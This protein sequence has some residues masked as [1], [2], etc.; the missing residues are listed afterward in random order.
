MKKVLVILVILSLLFMGAKCGGK[1][2]EVGPKPFFGGIEG[3][4][5]SFG[6][7]APLSEFQRAT[8]IPVRVVLKNKGEYSIPAGKIKVKLSGVNLANYN[9]Q[10]AANYKA[11][12]RELKGV[13]QLN[14]EGDELE[15]NFGN[16]NYK[17]QIS[18]NFI[19]ETL[20]AKICYEY[21]TSTEIPICIQPELATETVCSIAEEKVKEGTVSGSP[22]Q[23]TS[24]TEETVGG[25]VVKFN[26]VIENKG[27]GTVYSPTVTCE[28]LENTYKETLERG[29]F[30]VD[31]ETQGVL[32]TPENT[33]S[34][35]LKLGSDGKATVVCHVRS[36]GAYTDFLRM[37]LTFKY[38]SET[39]KQI[40]VVKGI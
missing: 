37:K 32:C 16:L 1:K 9:L 26:I 19:Q 38:I 29:K 33:N 14:P 35:D 11:S 23:V 28:D 36:K 34:F 2:K 5:A 24:V 10:N 30:H 20:K 13:S 39:S 21:Q 17:P 18:G 25:D 12:Q 8:D 40:K 3:I 6:E 22:L 7:N 4:I 15:I 27:S 31:I